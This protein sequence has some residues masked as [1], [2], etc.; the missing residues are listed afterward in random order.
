MERK[1]KSFASRMC[2]VFIFMFLLILTTVGFLRV[3]FEQTK[4]EYDIS[5]NREIERELTKENQL[6]KH[7]ISKFRSIEFLEPVAK[8]NGFRF[9]TYSDIVV[10]EQVV[11]AEKAE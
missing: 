3:K 7:N 10:V 6:L 9:P 8:K 1:K 5:K 11:L 4:T 2:S